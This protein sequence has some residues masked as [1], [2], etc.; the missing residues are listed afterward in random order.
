[1]PDLNAGPLPQGATTY[2]PMRHHICICML[3]EEHCAD[4]LQRP[5]PELCLYS[6]QKQMRST[7]LC[8]QLYNNV[9]CKHSFVNI[10]LSTLICQ[11]SFVDIHL[12]TF[13]CQHSFVNIHLSAFIC[14]HSFVNIHLST[15][16]CQI[17]FVNIHLST[18]V[19]QHSVVNI[20][21]STLV[22]QEE[23]TIPNRSITS[24]LATQNLDKYIYCTMCTH[25]S[26]VIK[27][28]VISED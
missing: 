5:G 13:I 23:N 4:L 26:I 27:L 1:M 16:I 11:H 17:S 3:P 7:L 9:I 28:L 12:S 22:L 15:F 25:V 6:T 14:Q 21:L 19:C 8:Q 20:H 18:F 10:Q 24:R 2:H